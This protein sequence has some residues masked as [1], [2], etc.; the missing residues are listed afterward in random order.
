MMSRRW[1]Y[2]FFL[3]FLFLLITSCKP[4]ENMVYMKNHNFDQEVSEARYN[5]LKLQEGDVLEIIVSA[6]DDIAVKPFNLSSMEQTNAG[7][8]PASSGVISKPNQYVV[9]SEGYVVMPVLGQVYCKGMTKQQ[10]KQD[11]EVRLKQ[12]L[13]DPLVNVKLVNFNVSVIGEVRSPGQKTSATERLTIFQALALAGDM[14]EGG[15]RTNVKLIRFS[16]E[17][18]KDQ[19]IALNLAESNIVDSKYYYLQQN[20]ILY[21]EPDRNK[22][23][24]AN[25]NPN[26]TLF[27]Q[28]FGIAVTVLTLIIRFK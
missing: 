6:Y 21:V 15:D 1:N 5:G 19:V 3:L 17:D 20:D 4:K 25:T 28:L 18:Q 24:A 13:T 9:S 12:Y 22:Q 11:L 27:F 16:E 7:V 26:K 10:L 2:S 23:V 14:T 8:D